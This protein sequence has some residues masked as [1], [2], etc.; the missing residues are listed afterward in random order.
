MGEEKLPAGLR[1]GAVALSVQSLERSLAFY[2]DVLGF[3]LHGQENG[4][5]RLGAGEDDLLVL[6]EKA[7]GQRYPRATGLYHFA[8]LVPSRLELARALLRLLQYRYPLQGGADHLVSEALYLADP[9][10]H[11]IEIYRDRPRDQWQW[12]GDTVRMAT[13]PL[14]GDG[15]L[16][17]LG[18]ERQPPPELHPGTVMGHVHLQIDHLETIRAFY[19]DALGFDLVADWMMALFVSAGGYHHHLG[20]NAWAGIGV[21]HPPADA[22]KLEWY[23]I[24]LPDGESRAAAVARLRAANY[25]V[26]EDGGAFVA[27][28]PAGITLRLLT[29]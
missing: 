21:P 25:A 20:L 24:H 7:A 23:S 27:Q 9:D 2:Q 4:S 28:D 5:A 26:Q 3:R 11:G 29:P 15:I 1:M 10:G 6:T 22:L 12:D 13:D 16:A 8:V 14:D 17:E 18:E 19:V